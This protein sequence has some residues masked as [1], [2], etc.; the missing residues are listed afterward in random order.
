MAKRTR[1][2]ADYLESGATLPD[3]LAS[4]GKLVSRRALFK[5][6]L[7]H[8]AGSLPEALREA[9]QMEIA[10]DSCAAS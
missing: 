7:G 4:A 3:A 5:I 2:V 8:D 6:R 9:G 1:Q 10:A